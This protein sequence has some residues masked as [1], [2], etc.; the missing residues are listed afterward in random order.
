MPNTGRSYLFLRFSAPNTGRSYLFLRFSMHN[1]GRSYLFLR[2]SAPNTGRSYLFLQRQT[3]ADLTYFCISQRQTQ[4]HLTYFCVS[5]VFSSKIEAVSLACI[6]HFLHSPPEIIDNN[7][8][9]SITALRFYCL[10]WHSV[11]TNTLSFALG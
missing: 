10:L 11:D 4:A 9:I 5:Q 2:F 8:K 6:V 1:T 7:Y 3:Q